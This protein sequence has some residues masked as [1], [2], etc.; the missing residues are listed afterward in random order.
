MRK[1]THLKTDGVCKISWRL[2]LGRKHK[3]GGTRMVCG[4]V[5][6][7]RT[8]RKT[9]DQVRHFLRNTVKTGP[10]KHPLPCP[11]SSFCIFCFSL[12]I[13]L[14][15]QQDMN[16][17]RVGIIQIKLESCLGEEHNAYEN[18]INIDKW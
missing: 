2:E 8:R 5:H 17:L 1:G 9:G 16:T 11:I 6:M 14:E 12:V 15:K 4:R 13:N 3:A 10:L 18:L 7:D